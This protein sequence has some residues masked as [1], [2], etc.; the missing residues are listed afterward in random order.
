MRLWMPVLPFAWLLCCSHASGTPQET[1][2]VQGEAVL[3]QGPEQWAQLVA[4][5]ALYPYELGA[6]MLGRFT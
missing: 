4:P 3:Q 6:Q 1:A 2:A 5:I